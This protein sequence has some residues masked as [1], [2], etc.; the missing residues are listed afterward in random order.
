[1]KIVVFAN[2]RVGLETVR[3]LADQ[4]C[5]IAALVVHPEAR[6]KLRDETIEASGAVSDNVFQADRLE[7][8]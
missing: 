6:A 3:F 8:L 4:D 5:T 7:A 1:M 2:N